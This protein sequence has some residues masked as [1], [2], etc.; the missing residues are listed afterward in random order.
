MKPKFSRTMENFSLI[1]SYSTRSI[2]STRGVVAVRM[3][4][5]TLC[6]C[7]TLLCFRLCSSAVGTNSGSL[8]RNTAVPFTTCGG[9]FSRLLMRSRNGTSVRRVL[10]KRIPVPRRHVQII[11]TRQRPNSSGTHAPSNSFNRLAMKKLV[12]TKTSGAISAAAVAARQFHS[13]HTTMKPM[14]PSATI[15]VDTAMP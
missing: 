7:S 4:R 13:F 14:M 3:V 5:M 12:S 8:V 2:G 11:A 10:F 1:P 6:S 9:R 15:V